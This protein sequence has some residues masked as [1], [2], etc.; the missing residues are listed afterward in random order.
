MAD[1]PPAR[2]AAAKAGA[3]LGAAFVLLGA[4][5]YIPLLDVPWIR[6]TAAP[7]LAAMIL[8]TA[9]G[10][11]G[12]ARLRRRWPWIL[13]VGESLMTL[14]FIGGIFGLLRLPATPHALPVRA[15][16]PDFTLPDQDGQH[17]TLSSF[18]GRGPILLVFYRGFW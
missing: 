1:T 18:R 2:R 6:S 3:L 9:L 17:V 8:G 13:A 15:A 14:L 11:F 5:T 7:N 4:F 12:A 10:I 16:A